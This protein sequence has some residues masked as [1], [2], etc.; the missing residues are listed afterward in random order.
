MTEDERE[1]EGELPHSKV[2]KPADLTELA[3]DGPRR[4]APMFDS[5][6]AVLKNPAELPAVGE[7]SVTEDLAWVD[8]P[9]PSTEETEARR[10][11]HEAHK[12]MVRRKRRQKKALIWT[13]SVLAFLTLLGAFWFRYTFGG[14]DRMPSVHGQAGANTPGQN[15]LLVGTNPSEPAAGRE[16]RRS[17]RDDFALSDLVM[18][19]HVTR[20]NRSMFAISIPRDSAVQIPGHGVGKLPDA[21]GFGGGEL[22]VRTVEELTGLRMDRVMTLDLSAFRDMT[23]LFD[24]VVVDVPATVCDEPAG[25]RRLDGQGALEYIALRTC[26]PGKDLDRVARQQSLMKALMRSAVDGGTVTHPLRINK[27]L[28]YGASNTTLEDGFG[29]PGILGTLWSLRHLR[30]TTTTFLTAPVTEPALTT[31]DGVEFVRLDDQKG[32]ELWDAVR[33]DQLAEYLQ[34]S[35]LATS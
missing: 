11:R 16:S 15:F 19:V 8:K 17:W 23:D 22:Y 5:R 29:Y 35:G 12:K 9:V 31:V 7:Q 2:E 33:R 32:S 26:M 27:L 14:L 3:P 1:P 4:T 34:L 28:R 18:V 25:P 30:A 24:G 10:E 21:F 13:A 6:P 20:D